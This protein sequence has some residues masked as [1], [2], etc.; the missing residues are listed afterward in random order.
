M[1]SAP[2]ILVVE[3]EDVLA[4]NLGTFLGNRF[5]E[6]RIAADGREA[7]EMIESYTFDVLVLDHGLPRISGLDTYREI[8]RRRARQFGCVMITG[9]P[10]EC[11]ERPAGALGI[12]H[13][14][15]KPFSMSELQRLIDLTARETCRGL[16]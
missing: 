1:Q 5:A 16:H 8:M 7:L 12:R 14:L 10:L 11:L 9:Y 3:D 13:L 15:C 4:Q 2:R 6:V